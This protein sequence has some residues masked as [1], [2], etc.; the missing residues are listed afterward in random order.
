MTLPYDLNILDVVLLSV[1][2]L[3]TLRGALR[4]FLD[5]VAGLVGILGGVW[6]AGRYYGELGPSFPSIR[7]PNGSTSSPM[8]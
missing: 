7:R 1:I 2:A 4:G 5:E 6:L 3:F 8:C